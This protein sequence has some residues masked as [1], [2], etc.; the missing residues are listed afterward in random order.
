[1]HKEEAKWWQWVN[2]EKTSGDLRDE[3]SL[4]LMGTLSD[5]MDRQRKITGPPKVSKSASK[6]HQRKFIA[7]IAGSH[8]SVSLPG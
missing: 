6:D 8:Q 5:T 3:R 2:S 1:K 7:P 4:S